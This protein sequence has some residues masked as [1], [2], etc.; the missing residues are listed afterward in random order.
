MALLT[1]AVVCASKSPSGIRIVQTARIESWVI[2]PDEGS[3]LNSSW[4]T[5][6]SECKIH[7]K[8]HDP[9]PFVNKQ[10]YKRIPTHERRES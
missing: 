7:R 8:Y 9:K 10:K 4:I 5:S 6:L 1:R 2:T 3:S